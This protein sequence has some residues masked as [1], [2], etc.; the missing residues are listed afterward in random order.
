MILCVSLGR[1]LIR[2]FQ[3]NLLEKGIGFRNT[4]IVGTGAR[5]QDLK[6]LI[7]KYKQLGYEIKGFVAL[8]KTNDGDKILGELKELPA[9]IDKYKI[10]EIIIALE[11]KDKEKLFEV[12][13]YCP[14]GKVTLKIMPDTYEIISGMVKT[15]QI[16]GMPLIEVMPEILP[17]TSRFMKRIIDVAISV[18]LLVAASPFIIIAVLMIKL[19][20]KGPVLYKQVRIGKD[21]KKFIMFKFR[22]MI[23]NAEEYGPEWAGERDPRITK[24][25][26]VMRKIYFDEIPQFWNVLKNDMSIVGPRPERPHF[27]EL[28][29]KEFPYYYKRISIKPGI[30]GW[31]QVKHKYDSSLDDVKVKLNYDFYYIENMSL[32]LDFKI[33]VNTFIVILFMKGH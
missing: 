30:T 2:S 12:I 26:R 15:N 21:G 31:A 13:K 20:S 32:R 17:Y 27:V 24:V 1:I 9:I 33:M 4:L 6:N 18:L 10:S 28:L 8:K 23:R 7:A 16:Y 25:G 11:S 5:A 3:I 14:Q 19:T 22:S 29:K